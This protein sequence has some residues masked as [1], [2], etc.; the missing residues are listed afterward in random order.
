MKTHS[1]LLA[2]SMAV[3]VTADEWPQYR[4]PH[5]TGASIESLEPWGEEGLKAACEHRVI[6]RRDDSTNRIGAIACQSTSAKMGHI[7]ESFN[8]V[9][10]PLPGRLRHFV[11][12]IDAA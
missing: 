2:A 11:G 8:G 5:H 4:G 12:G 1:L 7:A 6:H 10:D 3:S 9:L